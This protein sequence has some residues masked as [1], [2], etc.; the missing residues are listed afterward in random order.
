[1]ASET[2]DCDGLEVTVEVVP[3]TVNEIIYLSEDFVTN[4]DS[5]SYAASEEEA[6]VD[7]TNESY[8]IGSVDPTKLRTMSLVLDESESFVLLS[9]DGN[10]ETAVSIFY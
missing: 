1:M 5:N 8:E 3:Q 2:I 6:E 9:Q 4:N 10:I 7:D